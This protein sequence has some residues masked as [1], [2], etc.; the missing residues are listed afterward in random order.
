MDNRFCGDRACSASSDCLAGEVCEID[1]CCGRGNCTPLGTCSD[2]NSP[3]RIFRMD[4]ANQRS[5][6]SSKNYS[7]ERRL[8]EKLAR[9]I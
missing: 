5:F 9:G 6:K 3:S 1:S 8:F 2:T 4:I 7:P